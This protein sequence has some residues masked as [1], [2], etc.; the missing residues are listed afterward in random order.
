MRLSPF[1]IT[2]LGGGGRSSTGLS[3]EFETVEFNLERLDDM[4]EVNNGAAIDFIKID[5]EGH[6]RECLEGAMDLI[7][8]HKPVIACEMLASLAES[9]KNLIIEILKKND[10]K[11][12]Y[13]PQ[14]TKKANK[15]LRFLSGFLPL[16]DDEFDFCLTNDL[17][18]KNL[19]KVIFSHYPL[20]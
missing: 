14:N 7:N 18:H 3:E 10:Y 2:T 11:Y 5:I 9:E 13:E 8:K 15:F 17:S 1:P 6:E 20:D 19:P 4:K 12:I 16:Q